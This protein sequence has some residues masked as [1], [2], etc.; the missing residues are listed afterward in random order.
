M[1]TV[2]G[3]SKRFGPL[4]VLDG[5]DLDV[6]NGRVT[7]V[8]G[9]NGSGKTTLIK[10][11]LGMVKPDAGVLEIDGERLNGGCAYRARIGYMPQAARFPENLTGR[12]VLRMLRDLR[13]DPPAVDLDL[14]EAFGLEAELD[15][16]V[17]TLSGGTRQKLNAAVAL[18]FR[19]SLLVLD[20]PSS[21]LDPLSSATLKDRILRERDQGTTVI[22]TSHVMSEVDALADDV[23]FLLEGRVR[24]SGA[25]DELLRHTGAPGVERAIARLMERDD[26]RPEVVAA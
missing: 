25:K 16:R 7:A 1:I 13:D 10:A 2:R 11:L 8:L 23:V 9:P 15:K 12:E 24:W 14:V 3:L 17:G 20:E 19:P 18:L 21:G 4:Q 22:L 6:A 26:P 5:L